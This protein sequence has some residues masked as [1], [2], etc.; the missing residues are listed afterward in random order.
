M[1]SLSQEQEA[2]ILERMEK[3]LPSLVGLLQRLIH[4]EPCYLGD[5][6]GIHQAQHLVRSE[7]E[8]LGF[9]VITVQL[10]PAEVRRHPAYVR[11]E[12]WGEQFTHYA[13]DMHPSL[14]AQLII[15]TSYP[16][17]ALNGHV[18][19][20]PVNAP[21]QWFS[22][23]LWKSGELI[24]D[25]IYGRGAADM[26]GG[27]AGILFTL[28]HVVNSGTP[29]KTNLLVH[30]VADE[31][32]GG[33]GTLQ[34]LLQGPKP[35]F[36]LI[37]EP[38]GLSICRSSLGFHHFKIACHGIPV[39]MSQATADQNAIDQA[40]IAYQHLKQLW[41][42]LSQAICSSRD[43]GKSQINPLTFG[44]IQGGNDPAVPADFC[45]LEGVAFSA[46]QQTCQ[47][48]EQLLMS[49][50]PGSVAATVQM[51]AMSFPGA[52]EDNISVVQAL[53]RATQYLGVR[54]RIQGFVS[55]CDM[56][57]YT[58]FGVPS[59]IFGPGHLAQAHG[60][61]EYTSIKE[62]LSFCKVLLLSLTRI[63]E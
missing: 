6:S 63:G 57:L 15:D 47:D 17:L 13:P 3:D 45:C 58:H 46:P 34:C 31:E 20:E 35:D 21:N 9:Q 24:G 5:G 14:S 16:I 56:R 49:L 12:E 52:E 51:T 61:N 1:S 11:V 43:F 55:P 59:T 37:A 39:H 42:I 25:K 62:L 28:K 44:R 33:N 54:S 41:P 26:L 2:R 10:D 8:S 18:D 27:L 32:I 60:P 48:V 40:L 30:C 50:L 19:V 7:L 53:L 4:C 22:P 29:L 23:G 38:T 36:A